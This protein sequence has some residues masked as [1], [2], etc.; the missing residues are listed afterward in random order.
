MAGPE[1][2]REGAMRWQQYLRGYANRGLNA[3][4]AVKELSQEIAK[5]GESLSFQGYQEAARVYGQWTG[6][7][8]AAR[9]LSAAPGEYAITQDMVAQLPYGH[10]PSARGGPREFHV[11]IGYTA[12]MGEE[13]S[14]R[15]VVLAYTGGLPATVA[16]LQA[17]AEAFAAV[18]ASDYG[19]EVAGDFTYE[20]GEL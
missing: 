11:R 2:A 16:E 6:V 4:Q 14:Q 5:H 10:N 18:H 1:S 17:E 13:T 9:N 20:I 15:S 7:R 8:N 19:E 12:V 3:A